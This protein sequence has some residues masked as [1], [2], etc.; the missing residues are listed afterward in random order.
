[1]SDRLPVAIEGGLADECLHER[2]SAT[3]NV[4]ARRAQRSERPPRVRQDVAAHPLRG[5]Q[6][7]FRAVISHPESVEAGAA[8]EGAGS[9]L[10]DDALDI[11]RVIRPSARLSAAERMEIYHSSYRSRLIDCLADD[12]PALQYALGHDR[13]AEL[14]SEYVTRHPSTAPNLNPYG[15]RMASFCRERAGSFPER[16]FAADL[17]ALEW[18]LV[19]VLHAEAAP[20]LSL[21]ALAKIPM[22]R[23]GDARL[24][25][26]ATARLHRFD[27]PVN[28]FFQAFREGREPKIPPASPSATVVYRQGFSLWRMELTPPMAALLEALLCGQSLGE[29]LVA[30]CG[31]EG[32]GAATEDAKRNVMAWFREWVAGGVFARVELDA[33]LDEAT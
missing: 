10:G 8:E 31:A 1:M 32:E 19:E 30:M 29:G 23:W 26:S 15:R 20:T 28:A 6:T 4:H 27:H 9:T 2:A 5:L 18:T 17:A 7:W 21:E 25:P 33:E 3:K 22:E 16:A 13:F 12:Y 24:P 14:A 11:A